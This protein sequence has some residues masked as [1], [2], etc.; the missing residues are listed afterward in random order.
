VIDVIY[1]YPDT[2]SRLFSN[3][4]RNILYHAAPVSGRC[5]TLDDKTGA[6]FYNTGGYLQSY[7]KN[8]FYGQKEDVG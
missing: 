1:S 8:H 3:N 6:F 2:N 7:C 4:D 5:Y